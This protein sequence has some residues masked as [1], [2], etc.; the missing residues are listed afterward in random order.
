MVDP[1]SIGIRSYNNPHY[2]DRDN[3]EVSQVQENP[4]DDYLS[5]GTSSPRSTRKNFVE[6][7]SSRNRDNMVLDT[8]DDYCKEVQCIEMEESSR[9]DDSDNVVL[10]SVVSEG[11]ALSQSTDITTGQANSTNR[12]RTGNETPNGFAYNVLAQRL[13]CLASPYPDGS[14]SSS[15]ARSWSCRANLM[16]G[17]SSPDNRAERTPSSGFE[18]GFPGRPEGFGRKFPP[19]NLD[20]TQLSRNDSESSF[21]SASKTGEEDVTSLHTFVAGLKEMAKV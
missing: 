12:D 14:K 5:D 13:D 4:N 9:H 2:G 6:S 19:L 20:S 7:R 10:S 11:L 1:S 8:D 17:L 18:K 16:S 21:G 3:D 15:L